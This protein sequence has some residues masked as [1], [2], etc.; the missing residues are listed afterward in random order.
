MA[1]ELRPPDPLPFDDVVVIV[2]RASGTALTG[3]TRDFCAAEYA[4][5]PVGV[6]MCACEASSRPNVRTPNGLFVRMLKDR[7]HVRHEAAWH[8]VSSVGEEP[9]PAAEPPAALPDGLMRLGEIIGAETEHL[10]RA[11]PR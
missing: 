4:R 6:Y 9:E 11:R 1:D 8:S 10:R 7:D 5:H 3:P 2:E